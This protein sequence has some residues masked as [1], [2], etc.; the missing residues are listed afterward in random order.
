M[1][2]WVQMVLGQLEVA[3]ASVLR[4]TELAAQ[5]GDHFCEAL[6]HAWHSEI[7]MAEGDVSNAL[8]LAR[9]GLELGVNIDHRFVM[10]RSVGQLAAI[11]AENDLPDRALRLAAAV[12]SARSATGARGFEKFD[13]WFGWGWPARLQRVRDRLGPERAKRLWDEG[14][15]LSVYEA[16]AVALGDQTL[17]SHST[18]GRFSSVH[19]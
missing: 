13:F 19:S 10:V 15:Q 7:A 11:A 9:R 16:A 1:L 6:G 8:N 14:S 18:S 3:R 12:D 17:I 4:G 2:A 5:A